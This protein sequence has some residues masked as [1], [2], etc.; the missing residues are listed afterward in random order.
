MEEVA[1]DLDVEMKNEEA[2]AV[3]AEVQQKPPASSDPVEAPAS[4]ATPAAPEAPKKKAQPP[5]DQVKEATP[6]GES[7]RPQRMAKAQATQKMATQ[8]SLDKLNLNH[9]NCVVKRKEEQKQQLK[10]GTP[11]PK[12]EL[13]QSP[14]TVPPPSPQPVLTNKL[15]KVEAPKSRAPASSSVE[16]QEPSPPKKAPLNSDKRGKKENINRNA[17]PAGTI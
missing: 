6:A 16:N 1:A 14:S 12:A 7:R 10:G 15:D 17:T 8:S 13:P 5:I 3:Q 4:V 9:Y 2:P 11:E